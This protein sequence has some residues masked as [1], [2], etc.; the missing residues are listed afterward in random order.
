MQISSYEL[1]KI[2]EDFNKRLKEVV[3]KVDFYSNDELKKT[4]GSNFFLEF[5]RNNF[6]WLSK[7][8]RVLSENENIVIRD[9]LVTDLQ[10]IIEE[11][12]TKFKEFDEL[13]DEIKAKET[14][15]HN[16]AFFYTPFSS[17]GN[18]SIHVILTLYFEFLEKIEVKEIVK[19]KGEYEKIVADAKLKTD[20]LQK[21]LNETK[22]KI[23]SANAEVKNAQERTA[24]ALNELEKKV[25]A[26]EVRAIKAYYEDYICHNITYPKIFGNTHFCRSLF[27]FINDFR[28]RYNIT[29]Q[30]IDELQQKKAIVDTYASLLDNIKN[31]DD[32]TKKQ[33][34]QKILQNI[35]D[36]LLSIR[37]HGYLSKTLN[38]DNA[39]PAS[40]LVEENGTIAKSA[41]EHAAK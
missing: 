37:N 12:D 38:K 27:V 4:G 13:L 19:S 14:G 5:D 16:E 10:K 32:D 29:K 15:R 26:N 9:E 11:K 7:V 21:L 2:S 8:T 1:A 35:I 23:D 40:L 39:S 28:R 20:G 36:S 24:T 34:H 6:T 33:Y 18:K 25:S 3:D 31:F 17:W 22:E 41:V 30:I